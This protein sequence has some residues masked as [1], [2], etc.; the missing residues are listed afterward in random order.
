MTRSRS[1][2]ISKWDK[3]LLRDEEELTTP[4]ERLR[5]VDVLLTLLEDTKQTLDNF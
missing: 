3:P 2:H 4:W 1:G 5:I